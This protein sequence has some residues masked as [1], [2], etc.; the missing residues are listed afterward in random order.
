M[1]SDRDLILKHPVKKFNCAYCDITFQYWSKLE[2]HEKMKHPDQPSQIENKYQCKK[3]DFKPMTMLALEVHNK[4]HSE[5]VAQKVTPKQSV[6]PKPHVAAPNIKFSN[7][8]STGVNSLQPPLKKV[9][10][11]DLPLEGS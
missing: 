11:N 7:I 8:S 5:R 6:V 3:C 9:K 10:V 1:S 4:Q 2:T